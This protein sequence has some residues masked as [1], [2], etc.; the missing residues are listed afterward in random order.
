[1]DVEPLLY[2]KQQRILLPVTSDNHI[3]LLQFSLSSDHKTYY[4]TAK[5]PFNS[6]FHIFFFKYNEDAVDMRPRSSRDRTQIDKLLST[7]EMTRRRW[8]CVSEPYTYTIEAEKTSVK[9]TIEKCFVFER[10]PFLLR[11]KR[12]CNIN[13]HLILPS[14]GCDVPLC[15]VHFLACTTNNFS[16]P[17]AWLAN[18]TKRKSACNFRCN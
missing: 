6:L 4:K 13:I 8:W 18:D 7:F 3:S 17:F 9:C 10:N 14:V 16:F 2:P 5:V 15:C 12:V 1:M 11:W